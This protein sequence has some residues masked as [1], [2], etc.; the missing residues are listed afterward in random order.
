MTELQ[1]QKKQIRTLIS[2]RF[3]EQ[4][5]LR[6][7]INE[8]FKSPEYCRS[9]LDTIP[10]C[11]RYRSAFGYAELPNEVPCLNL[12]RAFGR[13]AD[14]KI[15]LP[16]VAGN[17]LI[18]RE[19]DFSRAQILTT[20]SSFGILEPDETCKTLCSCLPQTEA[21]QRR[22]IEILAGISPILVLTP[23]RAFTATGTRLGRGG[24]FY[25]RF[26]AKLTDLQRKNPA[27]SFTAV[28]LAYP[29]QLLADIP[30]ED[31]DFKLDNVITV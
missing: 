26:F 16:V 28:G 5:E 27:I 19:I 20:G 31:T 17:E 4:K 1:M 24:G 23:G 12:L 8:R 6:S 21:E 14:K 15:A 9:L 18:F 7:Q 30:T 25:D 2:Q 13:S 22:E 10:D 11:N 29:F 3:R